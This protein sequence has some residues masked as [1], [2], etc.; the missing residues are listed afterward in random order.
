MPNTQLRDLPISMNGGSLGRSSEDWGLQACAGHR[1]IVVVQPHQRYVGAGAAETFFDGV[2]AG[3][4]ISG[5]V[6]ESSVSIEA[7][8]EVNIDQRLLG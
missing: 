2:P 8:G 4:N 5:V 1:G 3:A 6:A 7:V